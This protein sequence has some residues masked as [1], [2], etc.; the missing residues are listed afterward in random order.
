MF[1][2]PLSFQ[3]LSDELM[4]FHIG[5][6]NSEGVV[7][8]ESGSPGL[9]PPQHLAKSL[10]PTTQVYEFPDETDKAPRFCPRIISVGDEI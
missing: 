9:K 4:Y 8:R 7:P 3:S 1:R 6:V 5:R 10:L 2:S